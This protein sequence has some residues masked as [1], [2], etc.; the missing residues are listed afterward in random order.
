VVARR[1]RDLSNLLEF[2]SNF[3]GVLTCPSPVYSTATL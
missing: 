1:S 2:V 3:S